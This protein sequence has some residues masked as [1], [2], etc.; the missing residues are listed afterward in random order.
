VLPTFLA[1]S[2]L[3]AG[4]V[5]FSLAG[6]IVFYSSLLVIDVILMRKYI[7]MGP[8]KVL[9]LEVLPGKPVPAPAE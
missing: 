1:A 6:F 3:S 5:L 7:C 2:S 8:S 9:G 4:Q